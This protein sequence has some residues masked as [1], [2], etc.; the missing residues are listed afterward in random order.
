M[1]HALIAEALEKQEKKTDRIKTFWGALNGADRIAAKLPEYA[2]I[3]HLETLFDT[4]EVNLTLRV[5]D[6]GPALADLIAAM[7]AFGFLLSDNE[8]L[9]GEFGNKNGGGT[10]VR[11][12]HHRGLNHT[13]RASLQLKATAICEFVA[14]GTKE[15]PVYEIQCKEEPS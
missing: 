9:N 3:V 13:I 6:V 7:R 8:W 12:F 14:V 4:P 10:V 2:P 1:T 15:V 11:V 5:D